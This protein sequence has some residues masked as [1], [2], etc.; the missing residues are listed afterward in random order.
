MKQQTIVGGT[1]SGNVFAANLQATPLRLSVWAVDLIIRSPSLSEVFQPY[2]GIGYGLFFATGSKDGQSNTQ[3][4][5][6]FQFVAGA[7]YVLTPE[8]AFFGEFKFNR[9]TIR[10][11]DVRGNYDSQL[12][13]FGLMW[14]GRDK[15][16][17]AAEKLLGSGRNSMARTSRATGEHRAGCL[18][19]PSSKA[20][21]REEAKAYAS[22]C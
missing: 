11:D 1:S 12:F 18:K 7:R 13:G 5:P 3:I 4:N 15:C 14:H 22:I 6:G 8:W 10:F 2:G 19:R 9:A 16:L 17:Q 20:A 21:T